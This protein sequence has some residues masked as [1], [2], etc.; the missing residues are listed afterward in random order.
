M[1]CKK[2]K[3]D[4][5]DNATY[6]RE[7]GAQLKEL[8]VAEK[9][10]DYNFVPTSVKLA[11]KSP[12]GGK[13]A[14][15]A[16][17]AV[18]LVIVVASGYLYSF[19]KYDTYLGM[20]VGFFSF[21]V[22]PIPIGFLFFKKSRDIL[23]KVLLIGGCLTLVL[24]IMSP[25]FIWSSVCWTGLGVATITILLG[26][27]S[28]KKT[29]TNIAPILII[30]YCL[31]LIGVMFHYWGSLVIFTGLVHI[32]TAT[33]MSFSTICPTVIAL[34]VLCFKKALYYDKFTY[35][36]LFEW[37]EDQPKKNP[38]AVVVKSGKFGVFN[39]NTNK[40]QIP[41]EYDYISW[42]SIKGVLTVTKDSEV[43]DIDIFGNKLS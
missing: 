27:L 20:I 8:T 25:L 26:I 6:C 43:Y 37:I 24:S 13:G 40:F 29:I 2:C 11:G 1:I 34:G 41:C 39:L 12:E 33:Q 4:N 35:T 17:L 21:S 15:F 32:D 10:P 5:L 28:L 14:V 22:L 31:T 38:Y 30:G 42:Q 9:Y 23:S 19:D 36:S 18:I 7:C 16:L 3:T